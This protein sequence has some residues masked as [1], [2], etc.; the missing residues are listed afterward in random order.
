MK[1]V[2]CL[3]FLIGIFAVFNNS[4]YAQ[5]FPYHLYDTRTLSELV[6]MNSG[7]KKIGTSKN[8]M[9]SAEPFYSAIRLE[10]A[11]QSRKI[12][13]EKMNLFKI[14]IES[15]NIKATKDNDPLSLI[16]KEFLFTEC[17]KEY[18]IPVQTRAANDFP[19]DLKKGDKMT[20]YLMLVGGIEDKGK[21]D[22]I[23]FTNSFKIY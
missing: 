5:G 9:L 17:G 16:D 21:W 10:Y 12:S 7:L 15:L 8:I 18:W 23:F 11:G 4:I 3:C 20:L 19:E 13:Q 22:I 14:W 6:E 2:F 1:K